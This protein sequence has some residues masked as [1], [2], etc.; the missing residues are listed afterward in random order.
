[1][2]AVLLRGV[3]GVE[4][5]LRWTVGDVFVRLSLGKGL[6][7]GGFFGIGHGDDDDDHGGLGLRQ[8]IVLVLGGICSCFGWDLC[9][10]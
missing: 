6:W 8:W 7:N 4:C 10:C 1:M 2:R 3:L 9:F 5:G